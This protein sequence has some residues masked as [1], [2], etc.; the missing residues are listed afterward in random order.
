M[1]RFLLGIGL[2]LGLCVGAFAQVPCVG[3]G[4][5]ISIPNPSLN[6]SQEPTVATFAAVGYDIQTASA[7]TDFGCL[8]GATGVVIRVQR[9][10]VFGHSSAAVSSM[11]LMY[12]TVAD[13]GGTPATGTGLGAPFAVDGGS[14]TSAKATTIFYTANPTINDATNRPIAGGILTSTT[15]SPQGLLFDYSGQRY[16]E[17]PTLR[18]PAQQLCVNLDG[19]SWSSAFIGAEFD[20]TEAVQ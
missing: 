8:T 13:S 17:A 4:G 7:A 20:W 3:V 12:R 15:T 1:K 14:G 11:T 19:G 2:W 9:V 6:C 18:G 5:V 16:T 10:R